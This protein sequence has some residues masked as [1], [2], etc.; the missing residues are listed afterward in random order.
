[1]RLTVEIPVVNKT[2]K[3][4]VITKVIGKLTPI[5]LTTVPGVIIFRCQNN[6]HRKY[7]SFK[8]IKHLIEK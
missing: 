7:Y 4:S 1:M 8:H 6:K 5:F 3:M 2:V